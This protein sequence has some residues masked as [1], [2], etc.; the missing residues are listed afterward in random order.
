M[1]AYFNV[2][3]NQWISMMKESGKG[4][5]GDIM[6]TLGKDGTQLYP[7]KLDYLSPNVDMN[8][9]ALTLRANFDNPSNDLKSGMYVSITLPYA[10]QK[11][12]ILAHTSSMGVDK[13]GKY[14]YVVND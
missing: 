11:G 10:N 8:T 1:Y 12:A 4:I 5:S 7:A 6:V 13:L 14:L 9:G 3:D 2:A